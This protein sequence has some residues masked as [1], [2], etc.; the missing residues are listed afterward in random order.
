MYIHHVLCA[1][2]NLNPRMQSDVVLVA[3]KVQ[4]KCSC[5]VHRA[6][7]FVELKLLLSPAAIQQEID[8]RAHYSL[9]YLS[10]VR[11]HTQA[12]KPSECIEIVK[13]NPEIR[14]IAFAPFAW[15]Q[16]P[17]SV[18]Y[19]IHRLIKIPPRL[20]HPQHHWH[21]T[22]FIHLTPPHSQMHHALVRY[23]IAAAQIALEVLVYHSAVVVAMWGVWWVCVVTN[24]GLR[25]VVGII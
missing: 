12:K 5:S 17:H 7:V 9:V 8:I 11:I 18:Q 14:S 19:P 10:G 22:P 2:S 15:I 23:P 4:V 6:P 13:R 25:W 24:E 1:L 3:V 20:S 16:R 21:L